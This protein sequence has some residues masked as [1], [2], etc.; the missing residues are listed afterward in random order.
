MK[1]LTL[2]LLALTLAAAPVFAAE[3]KR[4]L[5]PHE[6]GHGILNIAVEKNR[7]SMD[8]DVPGMDIVG[9]EHK[10]ESADQ[11]ATAA[12]AEKL[13]A[14]AL[15]LF[16]VP[17]SAGCKV[18]E[19]KVSIEAE[20]A[21]DEDANKKE[22]SAEP[23]PTETKAPESKAPESKDEKAK[24]AEHAGEEHEEH[25]GHNDYN[26]SYVLDCAKPSE[27]TS[28]QFGYFKAFEG[29]KALTVNVVSEKAQNS[30]EVTRDKPV[31]DLGA[32]M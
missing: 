15:V 22:A 28:I 21:H 17:V 27:I 18:T 11:K 23:K 6:H 29:A 3:E 13:L 19:A 8:L 30:Y 12:K 16:K 7:V 1:P 2:S 26:V 31:L 10:P 4:E 20:G 32:T 14:D 9:F 24:S 25:E 5:G